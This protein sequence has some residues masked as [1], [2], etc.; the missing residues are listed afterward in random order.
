ML[1]TYF[2]LATIFMIELVGAIVPLIDDVEN[3]TITKSYVINN[4]KLLANA[5]Y[6]FEKRSLPLCSRRYQKISNTTC[7]SKLC[8]D[9]LYGEKKPYAYQSSEQ[10][11]R[12]FCVA[13]FQY[14]RTS[15]IL[16]SL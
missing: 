2:I 16:A 15:L 13:D 12:D 1:C 4:K 9:S 7:T 10:E 3:L 5:V 14:G 8:E 6:V 11:L